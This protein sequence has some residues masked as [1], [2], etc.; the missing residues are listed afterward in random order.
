MNMRFLLFFF[1]FLFL[2]S[3][4]HCCTHTNDNWRP[5][6]FYHAWC[7]RW[8][9]VIV[10]FVSSCLGTCFPLFT[11]EMNGHSRGTHTAQSSSLYVCVQVISQASVRRSKTHFF[12]EREW[13]TEFCVLKS[14]RMRMRES[15]KVAR[16][17]WTH[18]SGGG[19]K[20]QNK[21]TK[22]KM[23]ACFYRIDQTQRC[24]P[25]LYHLISVQ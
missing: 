21:K 13:L 11:P 10:L 8:S 23:G 24:W 18:K 7:E 12:F 6:I 2:F 15:R 3:F 17:L 14:C 1:F 22:Q 19:I 25:R 9:I 16:F 20:G 4:Q 5:P